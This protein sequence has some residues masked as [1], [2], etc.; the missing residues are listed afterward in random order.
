MGWSRKG[1]R[2][3]RWCCRRSRCSCSSTRSSQFIEIFEAY[4]YYFF[5]IRMWKIL[6]KRT[7]MKRTNL[8][9]WKPQTTMMPLHT[10]VLLAKVKLTWPRKNR[11]LL[12]W[13]TYDMIVDGCFL[14]FFL[15]HYT[16]LFFKWKF[17]LS[18]SCVFKLQVCVIW[19]IILKEWIFSV[20]IHIA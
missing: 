17:M 9:L 11:H 7:T 4:S 18:I 8:K 3:S 20:I 12:D 5:Q 10:M 19:E 13:F 15:W 1:Y 6:L 14:P 16:L 2:W